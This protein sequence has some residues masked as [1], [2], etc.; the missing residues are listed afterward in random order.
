MASP[1]IEILVVVPPPR[2]DF[3]ERFRSVHPRTLLWWEQRKQCL[4]CVHVI[5]RPFQEYKG[6]TVSSG[7]GLGCRG[8]TLSNGV[9]HSCISAR[10]TVCGP[11]ARLFEPAGLVTFP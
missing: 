1:R 3:T 4:A 5:D 8:A 11:E 6:R 10:E 7:G 9:T 2:L